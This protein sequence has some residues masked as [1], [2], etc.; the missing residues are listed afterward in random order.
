MR[1]TL[2]ALF[3][4]LVCLCALP[5]A[6]QDSSKIDVFGGYSYLRGNP[7]FGLPSGNAS[8]W[9]GALT[10]NWNNWL[11]LKADFDGHY[12]CEQTMHNFLFGPQITFKRDSTASPFIH[13][14]VGISHG[15]S[16]GGFSDTVLGFA[17]GGGLDM[18]VGDRISIRVAQVD[19]LGTRYA[20][21]TQNH[22]RLSAG[23]V[24]HLG[25]K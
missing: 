7:G 13:G 10:Y 23:L 15:T 6:G 11:G 1:S 18:K 4:G 5:A 3:A 25:G 19:Y 9:E 24:F 21:A 12:C 17:A 20:D 2:L 8:G 14:L 16:F 22:L